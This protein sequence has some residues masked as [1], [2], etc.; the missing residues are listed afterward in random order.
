M[1]GSRNSPKF[2]TSWALPLPMNFGFRSFVLNAESVV[3]GTVVCICLCPAVVCIGRCSE[4]GK[5]YPNLI[6][7]I[8]SQTEPAEEETEQAKNETEQAEN[9]TEQAENETE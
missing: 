4:R 3:I 2:Q 9:E 1:V 8:G 7:Q 6:E 5:R